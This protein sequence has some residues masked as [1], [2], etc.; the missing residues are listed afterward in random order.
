MSGS[1]SQCAPAPA[2]VARADGCG[3]GAGHR[4]WPPPS[5]G[6]SAKS[7]AP[8]LAPSSRRPEDAREHRWPLQDFIELGALDSAV[9]CARY[10]ARHILWEWRLT[11][12]SDDVELV[13]AEL[14]TNAVSA[15]RCLDWPY[16]VRMWLLADKGSVLIVV[17]DAN[18]QPP[19]RIDPAGDAESGRGLLL[20]EAIS[21]RWDWRALPDAPG[22]VIRA[23]ITE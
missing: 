1:T 9:P 17:W 13:A 12:L 3:T 22:K 21:I 19:V 18:P 5:A 14:M 8:A 20:V 6:H 15:S 2:G 7:Q 11:Q 4:T 10:H 16:P 23:L